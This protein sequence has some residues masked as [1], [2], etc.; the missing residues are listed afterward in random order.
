MENKCF[1]C[2]RE[3]GELPHL[4]NPPCA[5]GNAEPARVFETFEIYGGK[6]NELR[7]DLLYMFTTSYIFTRPAGPQFLAT[8]CKRIRRGST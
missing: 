4:F 7:I 3:N 5:M 8:D 1:N 2:V 6:T